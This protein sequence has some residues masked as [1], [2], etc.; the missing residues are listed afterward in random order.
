RQQFDYVLIDSSPVFAADDAA[1][2]APK[3][4]GALF[5]VR[6]GFSSARV[7]EEAVQLLTQRRAKILG[8]VFNR[9]NAS[10]RSY[11]YYNLEEYFPS[12]PVA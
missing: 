9:S 4:D 2:L 5:V 8:L 6:S 10:A 7:V 1:S 11:Y 3:V 12:T